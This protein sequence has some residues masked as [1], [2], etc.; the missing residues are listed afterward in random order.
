MD[1]PT[2]TAFLRMQGQISAVQTMLAH[3][4]KSSPQTLDAAKAAVESI[5]SVSELLERHEDERMQIVA[6]GMGEFLSALTDAMD[7]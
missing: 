5:A 7:T 4:I 3:L 6:I 1:D 2:E